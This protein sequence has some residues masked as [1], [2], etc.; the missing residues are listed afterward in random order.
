MTWTSLVAQTVKVSSYNVETWVRSWV[1]KI[2]WRRK[3]ECTE[4]FK[5]SDLGVETFN[6]SSPSDMCLWA[7]YVGG[8]GGL[9]RGDSWG[10]DLIS[11][12]S[13]HLWRWA[14]Q[15]GAFCTNSQGRGLPVEGAWCVL[16]PAG[17]LVLAGFG[18][19][20]ALCG[21][22]WEVRFTCHYDGHEAL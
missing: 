3:W 8:Q 1:G 20:W 11:R 19:V 2:P 6:V 14:G 7:N 21:P 9:L 5:L 18:R 17:G 12:I 22:A 10:W 16:R 15:E 4:V 13:G